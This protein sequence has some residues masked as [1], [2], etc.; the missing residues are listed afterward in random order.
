MSKIRLWIEYGLVA[1]VLAVA[2]FAVTIKLQS[3]RQ[4][5]HISELSSQLEIASERIGVIASVNDAQEQV[6]MNLADQREVD[7]K[8]IVQLMD[9]YQNLTIIDRNLR[10]ALAQLENNDEAR[11]YLDI[12]VPG[13]VGCLFDGTCG[14]GGDSPNKRSESK[15]ATWT[16]PPVP[17]TPAPSAVHQPGSGGIVP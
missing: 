7:G 3:L 10:K 1:L 9:S 16:T 8:A 12:P 6:I 15:P 11:T 13:S 17:A 4:E 14:P 5:T 2:G